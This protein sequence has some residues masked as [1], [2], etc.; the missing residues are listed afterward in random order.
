MRTGMKLAAMSEVVR[1]IKQYEKN[2]CFLFIADQSPSIYQT[3]VVGDLL[4][5]PTSFFDGPQKLVNR[6]PFEVFF[7]SV[8]EKEGEYF[9]EFIKIDDQQNLMQAYA[10]LLAKDV[11]NDPYLWLWTHKR[12]KREGV[13]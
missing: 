10:N 4:G 12:W 2:A 8:K 6:Y 13:F 9:V 1:Y 3:A 7:Q 11:K 5:K